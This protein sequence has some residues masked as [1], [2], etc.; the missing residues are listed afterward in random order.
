MQI[1]STWNYDCAG[2]EQIATNIHMI[3]I[4]KTACNTQNVLVMVELEKEENYYLLYQDEP[5][6]WEVEP[7]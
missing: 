7:S 6:L 1:I 3:K 5:I 2:M 4:N